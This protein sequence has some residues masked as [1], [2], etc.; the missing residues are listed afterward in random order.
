[1]RVLSTILAPADLL[2]MRNRRGQIRHVVLWLGAIGQDPKGEPLVL[3]ATQ[4][5][6]RDANGVAIPIGIRLR[7]FRER[8]WYW[9]NFSHAHRIIGADAPGCEAPPPSFTEGGDLA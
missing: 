4:S 9:R 3:D 8:G 1:M 6:H 2:Y 7:P 5:V